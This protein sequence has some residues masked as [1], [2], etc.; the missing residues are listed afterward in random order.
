M[1]D[2]QMEI[3]DIIQLFKDTHPRPTQVN[4]TQAAEMLG[5][6][7]PTIRKYIMDGKIKLNDANLIPIAEIDKFAFAKAA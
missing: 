4:I 7:A 5:K 3:K 2:K 6:S 1:S